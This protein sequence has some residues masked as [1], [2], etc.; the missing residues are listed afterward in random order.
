M[1]LIIQRRNDGPHAELVD[2]GKTK[3]LPFSNNLIWVSFQ[4][5]LSSNPWYDAQYSF[6]SDTP[7][8]LLLRNIQQG[9]GFWD[10]HTSLFQCVPS[11]CWGKVVSNINEEIIIRLQASG[12]NLTVLFSHNGEPFR[13]AADTEWRPVADFLIHP[14]IYPQNLNLGE[15]LGLPKGHLRYPNFVIPAISGKLK[16]WGQ[17]V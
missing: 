10:F 1:Q 12:E 4:D 14:N 7:H 16:P 9:A 13:L 15:F 11:T 3:R 8:W 17:Q 2:E 6:D 5:K